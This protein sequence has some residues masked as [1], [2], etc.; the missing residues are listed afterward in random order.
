MR[1]SSRRN[2]AHSAD[3]TWAER[4][5]HIDQG[6]QFSPGILGRSMAFKKASP[7]ERDFPARL[8]FAREQ[9]LPRVRTRNNE[10]YANF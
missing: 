7:A 6:Q 3:R 9:V 5:L 4:R 10:D 2:G 1:V 8:S